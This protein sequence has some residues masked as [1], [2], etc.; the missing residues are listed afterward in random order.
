[1][2]KL[3]VLFLICFSGFSAYAKEVVAKLTVETSSGPTK[4]RVFQYKNAWGRNEVRFEATSL[5]R[6]G[7]VNPILGYGRDTDDNGTIDTY[8]MIDIDQGLV[9][10]KLESKHP[11]GQ[12]AIQKVLFKNYKSKLRAHV[13]AAYGA[14]FGLALISISNAFESEREFWRTLV[15][16]EEFY[17][18]LLDAKK[19]NLLTIKQYNVSIDFLH[20]GYQKAAEDMSKAKGEDYWKDVGT[21]IALYVTGAIAIKWAAKGIKWLGKPISQIGIVQNSRAMVT[22]LIGKITTKIEARIQ[23]LAHL[24]GLPLTMVGVQAFK[25]SFPMQMRGLMAKNI[26]Y[27][28]M[29]PIAWRSSNAF[30]KAVKGWKYIAFMTSLQLG[31]E[32]YARYD[33]VKSSDPTE[34]AK[35][36]LTHPDIFANVS[37]MSSN[38]FLMT[39]ASHGFK[40][41]KMKFAA[42]GFIALGNSTISN[43]V[44]KGSTDYE[45]VALDTSWEAL[46]GNAQIQVDLA[47]LS[48]FERL[49]QKLHNPKLKLIGYAIVL[50]DQSAGFIGYSKATEALQ[51][52]ENLQMV[53]VLVEK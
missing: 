53:P 11:W 7:T 16:L 37:Y 31:T 35:N 15:D 46:I 19:N 36:V 32:A 5:P 9:V 23:Q 51:A 40:A 30:R 17:I 33:E 28:K 14:V 24:K 43:L 8:F 10:T 41:K 50:V 1:M 27:R 44:I 3:L 29:I 25:K 47:S 49:S 26:I 34:F 2:T 39:A 22:K 48:Y 52:S 4:I 42:C 21:D 13:S 6:L 38:A 18:R 12:E 20:H 45:R